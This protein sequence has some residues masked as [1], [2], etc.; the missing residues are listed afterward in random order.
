MTFEVVWAIQ[1][2]GI[3]SDF[4]VELGSAGEVRTNFDF[5]VAS[6]YS[7]LWGSYPSEA[8]GSSSS[9]RR[10]AYSRGTTAGRVSNLLTV[11]EHTDSEA[12]VEL[13]ARLS[14]RSLTGTRIELTAPAEM[15]Y[16]RD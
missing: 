11:L 2:D 15:I 3:W 8:G 9:Q 6:A 10:Y 7:S 5:G 16:S 13:E 14:A 4:I 1:R 12:V